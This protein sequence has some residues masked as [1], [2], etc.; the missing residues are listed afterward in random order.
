MKKLLICAA[1]ASLPGMAFADSASDIAALKAQLAAMQAKLDALQQSVQ[2]QQEALSPDEATE[3][4]QSVAKQGL[5]V[6]QLQTTV[7]E[8]PLAGLSVTGYLD[9]SYIYN[10]NGHSASFLFANRNSNYHYDTSTIG[11]VYL[12]IKKT[13]GQGPTAP[14][15][16]ITIMPS[17]GNGQTL[18][19]DESGNVGNGIINSAVIN[20]PLD[21]QFALI[22]GLMP[23]FGGYEVQQSN[24]MLTLTHNLL[25]DFSDPGN[26]V[27]AGFTW[28]HGN[29]ATKLLLANEQNRTY[30]STNS[31]A[32]NGTKTNDVPT[33]TG[34]VDYTWSSAIDLGGSFNIGRQTLITPSAA[35]CATG[36]YGYQC[37]SSNPYSTAVF[38]E[39][40]ATYNLNDVILNAELDYGQQQRAAYNGGTAQW[41]GVSLLAHKKWNTD[42]LGRMG[43]TVRYDYLNNSAN[44]GGGGG[45]VLNSSGVDG[46]NG[47]GVAPSCT[48]GL[49]CKGANR[50]AVTADLLFYPTDHLTLKFEA[51]YD[52]ASQ[53]VFLK[54]D[55]GYT[56]NNYIL[57]SQMVYSF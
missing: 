56:R 38:G 13:F 39:V 52:W 24:Q 18:L 9:P 5:K 29:W 22:A 36:S 48:D 41:Y 30:G 45:I 20:F 57:G 10:K 31:N 26:Y 33:L 19:S 44:G 6:D 35:N 47:W 15:A 54:N 50:Q 46:A 43:M 53:S 7:N 2:A 21:D 27:G 28:A 51:R 34:R 49:Q 32:S 25:Y 1:I 12:D 37:G 17:R 40:D 23:G 42:L 4:K 16:E 8:G 3:M 14:Y 55:G 11:D